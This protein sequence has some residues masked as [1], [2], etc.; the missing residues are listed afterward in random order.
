M[1]SA[2]EWILAALYSAAAAGLSLYGLVMVGYSMAFLLVRR[3]RA[4]TPPALTDW[5]S[6]TVQLP[7]YNEKLVVE[8]LIDRVAA[9]DYPADKLHIQV[10]DDSTDETTNLAR[11]R[12]HWHASRGVNIT[13]LHRSQPDGHKAG[14]LAAGL[15]HS[16]SA[17]VAVFD[18]DFLPPRDFLKRVLPHFDAPQFAAPQVGAV[19]ARWGH[20]NP[21]QNAL[22]RAQAIAIDGHHIIEQTVRSASGLCLNF[23]GSAGVW[24]RAC[25]DRAG[26]WQ[27]DTLAEDLDLSYRAQMAGWQILYLPEV[28]VPAEVPSRVA[29]F[30]RQ[31]ARWAKGSVQALLKLAGPIGRS[32]LT[33]RQRVLGWLH[34]SGYFAHPLMLIMLLTA[35]PL[36]LHHGPASMHLGWLGLGGFGAPLLFALSQLAGL[37]RHGLPQRLGRTLW[38]PALLLL[39]IGVALNNTVAVVEALTGYQPTRFLRTPK[40]RASGEG[41]LEAREYRLPIHWT[42][43]GELLLGVYGLATA[44]LAWLDGSNMVMFGLLYGASFLWVAGISVWE[45]RLPLVGR[46]W[47]RRPSSVARSSD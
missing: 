21:T 46:R 43:W 6:V 3:R 26:G 44:L 27:A 17:F 35:L 2:T 38:L 8:R 42:T 29:D 40:Y 23:N 10:L 7:L 30:K 22:T 13:L 19:Q 45:Q 16:A 14:A 41:S 37:Q 15:A 25:I 1:I 12:V 11:A 33:V 34:L 18:A 36:V 24:R 4:V 5:P 47:G 20:L 31:Q 39:G 9:L 32:R 28:V